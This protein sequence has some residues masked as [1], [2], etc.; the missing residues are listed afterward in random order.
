MDHEQMEKRDG[1]A[2]PREAVS[3]ALDRVGD[4]S[5]HTKRRGALAHALASPPRGKPMRVLPPN[6]CRRGC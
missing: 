2:L 4:H 6:E 3:S 5:K 1:D